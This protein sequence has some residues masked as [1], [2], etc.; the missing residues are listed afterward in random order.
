MERNIEKPNK[1]YTDRFI[2]YSGITKIYYRKTV[3]GHVAA[4]ANA[5]VAKYTDVHIPARRKSRPLPL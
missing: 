5:T 1:S 2:T 3:S 4:V